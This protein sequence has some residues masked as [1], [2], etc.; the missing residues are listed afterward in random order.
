MGGHLFASDGADGVIEQG[1]YRAYYA[2]CD[3]ES[4]YLLGHFGSSSFVQ[5]G[6]EMLVFGSLKYCSVLPLALVLGFQHFPLGWEGRLDGAGVVEFA[7]YAV[8]VDPGSDG[9]SRSVHLCTPSLEVGSWSLRLGR[10]FTAY[11]HSLGRTSPAP[12]AVELV[13]LT[14]D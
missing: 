13:Y 7:D 14:G 9:F 4:G 5:I 1:A 2:D 11:L 12:G 8:G 3:D 10:R 6:V